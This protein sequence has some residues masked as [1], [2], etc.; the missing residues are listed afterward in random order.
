MSY[1]IRTTAHGATPANID[2]ER[3]N[4]YKT[5]DGTGFGTMVQSARAMAARF[6]A[7]DWPF[8]RKVGEVLQMLVSP[9][10]EDSIRWRVGELTAQP[11][12]E[13]WQAQI[14]RQRRGVAGSQ[15][16]T[17]RSAVSI[18]Y[19]WESTRPGPRSVR[20]V[21]VV[22]DYRTA[23]KSL[24][25]IV[26]K[27][28]GKAISYISARDVIGSTTGQAPGWIGGTDQNYEAPSV[29]GTTF[30]AHS[31]FLANGTTYA[32]SA[33]G[34]KAAFDALRDT[35]AE[36]DI[37][38]EDGA[39]ILLIHGRASTSS[40]KGVTGYIARDV[41]G[42][43]Y[44][45]DT[46]RA[47]IPWYAHGMIEDSGILCVELGSMF[48][49]DQYVAVKSY[50]KLS[51]RNPLSL[52]YPADVGWG[53]VV[54]DLRTAAPLDQNTPQDAGLL[55]SLA[56]WLHFGVAVRDPL[57]GAAAQV[58]DGDDTYTDPTVS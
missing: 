6:A 49:A 24:T 1:G 14:R 42:M 29:N 16:P 15:I 39:P 58:G 20:D 40:V 2:L 32:A 18:G 31:H 17:M 44:G 5:S 48:A 7:W 54:F 35:F 8:N 10:T 27:E 41:V 38:A 4:D 37:E 36:H 30:D 9:Q 52:F 12:P 25:D 57:A 46:D 55:E 23:M 51:P 19:S 21:D 33:A 26:R 34:R 45:Q 28:V 43:R 53:P 56:L 11:V 47:D 3:L 22:D 50:G 13:D